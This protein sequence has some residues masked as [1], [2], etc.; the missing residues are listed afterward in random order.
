MQI[1]AIMLSTIIAYNKRAN[2]SNVHDFATKEE[3]WETE[4]QKMKTEERNVYDL[5]LYS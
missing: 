2:K 1:V 3:K 4:K 5:Y